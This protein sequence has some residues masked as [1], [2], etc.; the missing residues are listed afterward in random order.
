MFL[1]HTVVF[2]RMDEDEDE[3][4]RETVNEEA[5][6]FVRDKAD[7]DDAKDEVAGS[8]SEDADETNVYD[9]SDSDQRKLAMEVV[10]GTA[11]TANH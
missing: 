8:L 2:G 3:I 7:V 11:Y 9:L 1:V 6:L 10:S 5:I 4:D